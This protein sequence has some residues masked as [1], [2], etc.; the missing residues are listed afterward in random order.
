[1]KHYQLVLAVVND[2]IV[3]DFIELYKIGQ[4][5]IQLP[6]YD[7]QELD[8]NLGVK[9]DYTNY[10]GNYI[11]L[12]FRF[13]YANTLLEILFWEQTLMPDSI[14][15]GQIGLRVE[16]Q[17][18]KSNEAF[19]RQRKRIEIKKKNTLMFFS[20]WRSAESRVIYYRNLRLRENFCQYC[21]KIICKMH[22]SILISKKSNSPEGQTCQNYGMLQK[23]SLFEQSMYFA[24]YKLNHLF[25]ARKMKRHVV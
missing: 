7:H 15:G 17:L 14:P 24:Y 21:L 9:L 1:M 2:T 10:F 18:T 22:S 13:V 11:T 5:L 12:Y 20:M 16:R 6:G 4:R 3:F 23:E 8:L 25:S 19:R